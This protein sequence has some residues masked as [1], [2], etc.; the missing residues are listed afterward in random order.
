M[1]SYLIPGLLGLMTGLLLRW[2]G[3]N[4]R[5]GLRFAL[6]LRRSLTLRTSLTAL[7]WGILLTALLMWL[8]VI[9][10]DT[11]TVLPLSLGTLL[12]GLLLGVCAGLCGFTPTTA[13]AGLGSGCGAL[14]ALCVLA[15]CF[16]MTWLLP[17]LTDLLAPLQD[18]SPYADATLFKV[19]LDEQF[20]FEG[21]FL[22]MLC[23]GALLAVWG[24][25]VPSPRAVIIP[26]EAVAE[27][28]AET[29]LPPAEVPAP[30]PE[31]APAETIIAA[32]EGEEP[33]VVDAGMDAPDPE[34]AAPEESIP[35][36]STPEESASGESVPEES[37]PEESA[38]PEP[39]KPEA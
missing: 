34:E 12:G 21:G 4:R 13:F 28:A 10:V 31:D 1:T 2:A 20:L 18:M 7:G 19:T 32:L 15:G 3:M 38:P 9:D 5:D 8:A 11:V 16:G 27:R 36:E 37:A 24:I 33:L 29:P 17:S 25:C 22:G 39:D 26:D 14:E 23:L 35:E 6:G 30:D